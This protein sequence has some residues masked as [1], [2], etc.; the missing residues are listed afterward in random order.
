MNN[1]KD[2]IDVPIR[3]CVAGLALLGLKPMMSCC[4]FTYKGE[5]KEPRYK[6]HLG[7]AYIY[8]S[9]NGEAPLRLLSLAAF[10]QWTINFLNPNLIDF[11]AGTW[12]KDHPWAKSGCVHNYEIFAL[13]LRSLENALQKQESF[14]LDKVTL[15]DGNRWYKEQTKHWQYE[16]AED[17]IITKEEYFSL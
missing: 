8:I 17:W 6:S 4:G 11:Y 10:S 7:K 14:F 12:H 9:Y 1:L 5:E 15:V 2:H 3:K 16:P 13:A